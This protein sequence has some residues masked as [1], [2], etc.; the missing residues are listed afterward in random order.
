MGWKW[1]VLFYFLFLLLLL[2][3][4]SFKIFFHINTLV[5]FYFCTG[6][7]ELYYCTSCIITFI[8]SSSSNGSSSSSSSSTSSS[9][10]RNRSKLLN[11]VHC[12]IYQFSIIFFKLPSFSSLNS[13]WKAA[14][15]LIMVLWG[16]NAVS[17]L[18]IQSFI[19]W[20]HLISRCLI[21]H[22][23]VSVWALF[24]SPQI[25]KGHHKFSVPV[26]LCASHAHAPRELNQTAYNLVLKSAG[27]CPVCCSYQ[28]TCELHETFTEEMM[29]AVFSGDW[30]HLLHI[31]ITDFDQCLH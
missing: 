22:Q 7:L 26:W 15:T 9:C 8:V 19:V 24:N 6:L 1:S 25:V 3:F 2:R 14:T 13:K 28:S 20:L 17:M 5:L 10:R 31:T 27:I 18:Q 23:C 11:K 30:K 4:F 29:S 12:L 21:F 16:E